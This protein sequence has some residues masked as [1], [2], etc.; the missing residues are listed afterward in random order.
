MKKKLLALAL[1][2]V[3]A[4]SLVACSNNGGGSDSPA[5]TESG[6]AATSDLYIAMITDVGNIDDKSFN[7]G[8][9]NGAK[10]FAESIGAKFDYFRP[11]EDTTAARVE[12]MNTAIAKGAN[13]LVCPGYLFGEAFSQVPQENPNVL[14]LGIDMTEGD[15][16]SGAEL[17][18]N[19][20]LVSYEEEQSGYLAGYAAVMSGYRKLGYLG[21]IDVPSVV[22]YGNGFIQGADDA[23]KAL[24]LNAG[25]VTIKH[26]YSQTFSASDDVKVKM[27]GWYTDGTEVVFAAGGGVLYSCIAAA[28][29]TSDGKIIGV[30]VD[31]V[32]ESDRIITSAMK[33]I[34][35]SVNVALS[36]MDLENVTWKTMGGTAIKLGAK[37]DSVG[38][39]TAEGSWK[40]DWDVAEYEAL[41]EQ[42]KAGEIEIDN[43]ADPTIHVETELVTVD[44]QG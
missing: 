21:G 24:G 43:Q 32:A 15:L 36:D 10:Q 34:V 3:M 6:N 41:F 7:E 18:S 27:D 40:L 1:A 22:R 19:M 14:F 39:P 8:T 25:D 17:T 33:G 23:A 16:T 42:L 28:D 35:A 20:I 37:D 38:L 2:A 29:A 26:W 12:T 30:D 13:V 44:Y 11:S 31:Q 4:L 5:P 9:Y